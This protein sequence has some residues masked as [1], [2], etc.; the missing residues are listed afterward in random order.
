M[1]LAASQHLAGTELLRTR[2]LNVESLYIYV[3]A[4]YRVHLEMRC[5]GA[6]V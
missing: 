6:C 1:P 4:P 5:F 3:C 2:Q